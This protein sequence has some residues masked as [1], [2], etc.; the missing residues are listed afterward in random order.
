[1][2]TGF[3]VACVQM[4]AEI[5]P[6]ATVAAAARLVRSARDAGAEFIT[7]PENAG[8]MAPQK[9]LVEEAVPETE[10]AGV[11]AYRALAAEIGTWL[12]VGSVTVRVAEGK[13][14]NRSLLIDGSGAVVARYDKIHMFDVDLPNGE[15]Y[16]ES[17]VFK[18]GD[19]ACLAETPWGALGMTVC[20]DVRFPALYRS[21]ALAGASY[22]AIP[23]AFTRPTGAAHWHVLLRARAIENGCYVFAPAQCGTHYGRRAT[24]GHAL[25]VSPWGEVLADAGDEPGF[26]V[27]DIDPAAVEAARTS[28]PSLGHDRPFAASAR[29]LRAA[30]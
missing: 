16:R 26:V 10:H 12:L 9:V 8:R 3:R 25:I 29:A 7:L 22:L 13:L 23:S 24:F 15:S 28:V 2:S 21:L 11:L 6:D 27:A 18:P 19:A 20:Y 1:M 14:A 5:D 17:A 4:T 30:E